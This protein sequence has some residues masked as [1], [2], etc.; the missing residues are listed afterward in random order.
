[1]TFSD[2]FKAWGVLTLAVLLQ[3]MF[4]SEIE[5]ASGHPDLVLV[6]LVAVALRRG[7]LIGAAV[8]FW[9]G[10]LLDL[11]AFE[12]LGLTALLLTLAGYGAGRLGEV[13]S[14]SSP[15]PPLIAV[16][17]TTVGVLLGSAFLHFVLGTT[18]SAS[19]LFGRVL[20][21]TLALNL[22]LAW[23]VHRLARRVFPPATRERREVSVVV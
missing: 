7:P 8:G 18:A 22:L 14:K 19:A 3:I 1:V 6:A 11:A 10:F 2:G 12:T 16:A 17:L 15:H 9:A 23:P 5:V 20:L 4:V 21:P 13:M